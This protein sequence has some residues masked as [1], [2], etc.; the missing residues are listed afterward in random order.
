MSQKE[1]QGYGPLISSNNS[2]RRRPQRLGRCAVGLEATRTCGHKAII[3]GLCLWIVGV[4]IAPPS[5]AQTTRTDGLDATLRFTATRLDGRPFDAA[6]LEGRAVLLD[7]WAVWCTPCIA[8]FPHLG[9][10]Q[11]DFGGRDFQVLGVAVHSGTPDDVRSHTR[12]SVRRCRH[13]SSTP[14][15]PA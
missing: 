4:A 1:A 12:T 7:F 5:S 15:Q 2:F 13:R 8:A 10:L 14:P 6:E 3:A 11:H 9:R